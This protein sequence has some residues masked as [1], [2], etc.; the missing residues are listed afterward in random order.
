[1]CSFSIFSTKKRSNIQKLDLVNLSQN[2]SCAGKSQRESSFCLIIAR[3]PF[4][5]TNDDNWKCMN[6]CL[7]WCSVCLIIH[8][9]KERKRQT[10]E[11][12]YFHFIVF[13][14]FK[15]RENHDF[16]FHSIFES[17]TTLSILNYLKLGNKMRFNNKIVR[18]KKYWQQSTYN[19]AFF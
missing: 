13:T 3:G 17:L 7:F 10:Q 6:C 19:L 8:H 11:Q 1:M 16:L 5:H 12:I 9:V 18:K 2:S 4:E 15:I 14:L